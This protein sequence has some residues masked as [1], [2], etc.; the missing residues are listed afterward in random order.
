MNA[1]SPGII[2]DYLAN[3]HYPDQRAYLEA[4][5]DAM[6]TEYDAIVAA[7]LILQLDCPDLALGRHL[8][9]EPL[10]VPMFRARI[11]ERVEVL[12]HALR[13]VPPDRVRIHVCWG[14]YES[15]HH[16]DVALADI[17]DLVLQARVGAILFEGANPHTS[18]SGRSSTM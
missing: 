3:E 4:L 12:N 5:A 17:V 10:D 18:T 11:A 1:A 8:A 9:A 6:K 16:H 13:D 14:N 2:A 15:P 7:G